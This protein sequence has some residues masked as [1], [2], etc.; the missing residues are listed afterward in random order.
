MPLITTS[1]V[2]S[3][4]GYGFLTAIG[5][6][7]VGGNFIRFTVT[8]SGGTRSLY[9]TNIMKLKTQSGYVVLGAYT[10]ISGANYERYFAF[11]LD[12]DMLTV[13]PTMDTV[14]GPVGLIWGF[15]HPV[16]SNT[17]IAGG[18]EGVF[19]VANT[20]RS[21]KFSPSRGLF[22]FHNIGSSGGRPTPVFTKLTCPDDNAGL[23]FSAKALN[24]SGHTTRLFVTGYSNGSSAGTEFQFLD[25]NSTS[26]TDNTFYYGP[27]AY[28]YRYVDPVYGMA[29]Y[30]QTTNV[31]MGNGPGRQ[32]IVSP[33]CSLVVAGSNASYSYSICSLDAVGNPSGAFKFSG[34]GDNIYNQAGSPLS[35]FSQPA[36][37]FSNNRTVF[38]PFRQYGGYFKPSFIICNGTSPSSIVSQKY[39]TWASQPAAADT[40]SFQ[41]TIDPFEDYAYLTVSV[42]NETGKP[43]YL[44]KIDSSGNIQYVVKF[45]TTV[46]GATLNSLSFQV[47]EITADHVILTANIGTT[48]TTYTF[49]YRFDKTKKPNMEDVDLTS[50]IG[51][52]GV[53]ILLNASDFTS[54]VVENTTS[55]GITSVST[56]NLSFVQNLT[57]HSIL[58]N[59]KTISLTGYSTTVS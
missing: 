18:V 30:N 29:T 33:F 41:C 3:A 25:P 11:G 44:Y 2:A 26:L 49:L 24:S 50:F 12:N 45:L 48:T 27:S 31:S 22:S 23:Q 13:T 42:G 28:A 36:I 32:G 10:E 7:T 21:S 8:D 43:S 4:K 53:T 55:Y 40:G 35:Q 15:Y 34:L 20:S 47:M 19:G 54:S 16:A 37:R 58:Q 17:A 57:Q 59:Q 9:P 38:I 46:S 39:F 5:F 1:S 14:Y 51:A 6:Q 52:G 56:P